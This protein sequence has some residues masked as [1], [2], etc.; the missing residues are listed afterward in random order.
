LLKARRGL[1][2]VNEKSRRGAESAED[3]AA[4][5]QAN[6]ISIERRPC[7]QPEDM[8]AAICA[9]KPSVD[10]V[11]L[12]GGD[13]TLS[14]AAPALRET[15]LPLGILPLGTANDLARTLG[16][17]ADLESAVQII[18][19][20]HIRE[21]DLGEV[22]G[23]PFFN[24]AA[25]GLTPAIT[26]ELTGEIKKRWGTLAYAVATFRALTHVR[27]LAAELRIDGRPRLIR[28]VQI[29]VGNGRYYGGGLTVAESARIDDGSLDVYSLEFARVWKLALVYPAFRIGRQ[30]IWAEV[31]T[32]NCKEVEI[33]TRR[34][35]PISTD[36]EITTETP[37]RFRVLEKAVRVFAPR[38]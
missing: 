9:A 18:A 26:R 15:R 34:P 17:E 22:N 33:N 31:R 27:R 21:I 13:G 20:G 16:I 4:A 37:A 1:L 23:I 30:D 2:I 32:A 5:L 10:L 11:I 8:A 12:G 24:V 28:T 7:S 35:M 14:A 25:L 29:A 6:G 38:N 3:A 36:G 19:Q